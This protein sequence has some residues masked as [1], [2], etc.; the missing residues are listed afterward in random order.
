MVLSHHIQTRM[1]D[2]TAKLLNSVPR[3][4]CGVAPGERCLLHSGARPS[5]TT[6][7][8]PRRRGPRLSHNCTPVQ[9]PS[10]SSSDNSNASWMVS[11]FLG[12]GTSLHRRRRSPANPCHSFAFF[13]SPCRCRHARHGCPRWRDGENSDWRPGRRCGIIFCNS[14]ALLSQFRKCRAN[15]ARAASPSPKMEN[16]GW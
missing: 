12:V 5:R 13:P 7:D 10:T 11:T 16:Q 3:P 14:D 9:K 2:L 1:S 8:F 6:D 4:T 15:T